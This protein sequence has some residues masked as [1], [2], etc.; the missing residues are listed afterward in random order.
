MELVLTLLCMYGVMFTLRC[1]Q[2]PGLVQARE[3]VMQRSMFMNK[4]LSCS[5][6]TGFHAGWMT[7]LLM[8]GTFAPTPMAV[9]GLAS[10]TFCYLFD[11]LML[12]LE[13]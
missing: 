5:F 3:F 12:K 11:T 2:L 8:K 7:Y 1:A 4:L 6:C 10:A 9:Y 13:G